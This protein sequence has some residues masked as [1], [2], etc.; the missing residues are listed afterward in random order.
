MLRLQGRLQAYDWGSREALPAFLGLPGDG[1]PWAEIWYGAH[2]SAPALASSVSPCVPAAGVDADLGPRSERLD[3]WLAENPR[4]LREPNGRAL[5]YLVKLLAAARPLSLQVHP[6][7]DQAA[8]GFAREGADRTPPASRNYADDK[9]KPETLLA[10]VP[11]RAL[12]GFRD[13]E[14]VAADLERLA[15]DVLRAAISQLRQPANGLRDAFET[16][17]RLDR[18]AIDSALTALQ[19]IPLAGSGGSG[20]SAPADG[21]WG[22]DSLAVAREVLEFYP[23]DVGVLATIFLQPRSLEPGA[24]LSVGAGV[25]HCYLD[26]LGLEVMASSD[27]VIRAGLTSKRVDIDELLA[28]VDFTAG[29]AL[30]DH[31]RAEGGANA[32]V[33]SYPAHFSE[34]QVTIYGIAGASVETKGAHGAR[35]AIALDGQ[36]RAN[37]PDGRAALVAGDAVF[38]GAGESL[39]LSGHG[40]VAVVGVP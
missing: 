6:N 16:V 20:G 8:R 1:R 18:G 4:A 30:V 12:A 24:A 3:R 34:Y 25:V 21:T 17:L 37:C 31:P 14:S 27:N 9:H 22:Q 11:T 15:P 19:G 38:L 29:G 13:A 35:V 5:P 10:L 2:P 32:T 33:Q 23:G 40:R 28:I 36:T 7:S 26:G 39:E